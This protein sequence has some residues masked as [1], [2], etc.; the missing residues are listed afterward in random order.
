[1]S[2]ISLRIALNCQKKFVTEVSQQEAVFH[3]LGV[4]G[5]NSGRCSEFTLCALRLL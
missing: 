1:M 2:E 4:I 5:D 3:R